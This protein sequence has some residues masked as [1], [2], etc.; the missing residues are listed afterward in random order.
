[1]QSARGR[2]FAPALAGTFVLGLTIAAGAVAAGVAV[3][4]PL[5]AYDQPPKVILDVLRAP[6]PPL[7]LVSPTR[8]SMLL[9][10]WREFPPLSRVATPILKLAGSRVEIAN[11]SKHDTPG[12]Y[13]I[14]PCAT[15]IDLVEL[16]GGAGK[17]VR[18]PVDACPGRPVW[19]ADGKHFAFANS[20]RDAV[21][22]WIGDATT[23]ALRKVPHVRLNPMLDDALQWM[24]DHK[25]LL[26]KPCP[27]A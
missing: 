2:G 27:T 23:G 12:G 19:A 20:A 5:R 16:P 26:V 15:S 6:S 8:T 11:H 7:P 14:T 9:V 1:M 24:P 10:S 22:L 13:G 18:L 17:P 25:T 4:P 21:E 3:A